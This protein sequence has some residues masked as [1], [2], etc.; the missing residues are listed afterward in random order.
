MYRLFATGDHSYDSLT[1]TLNAADWR[2]RDRYGAEKPFDRDNTR[3]ILHRWRLYRGDLPL[4][5]PRRKGTTDWLQGGHAPILPVELC[6]AVGAQLDTRNRQYNSTGRNHRKYILTGVLYCAECGAKL[7]GAF[8]HGQYVYRHN[9]ARQCTE[10]WIV[11]DKTEV[12]LLSALIEFVQTEEMIASIRQTLASIPAT[13]SGFDMSRIDE[14]NA[15]LG[16]LEDL[17]IDGLM[18][19]GAYLVKRGAILAELASL[20]TRQPHSPI[21]AIDNI[22]SSLHLINNATPATQQQLIASL[23]E[24]ITTANGQIKTV[25]PQLWARPFFISSQKWAGWESNPHATKLA[26]FA[27]LLV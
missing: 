7:R 4:G 15:K 21:G 3:D 9:R 24:R 16:R 17:Y 14:L 18:E 26:E 2:Y 6:D 1:D 20:Q 8:D 23:F 13:D 11:A 27:E 12:F 19:R 22:I 10:R 5:N 25:L